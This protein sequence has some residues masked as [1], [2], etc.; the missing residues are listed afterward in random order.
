M[1]LAACAA[2]ACLCGCVATQRDILDLSAQTD[3]LTVQMQA[4]RKSLNTMQ[5]NQADLAVKLDQMRTDVGVL[6]E[7][8]KDNQQ[9]NSRLAAKMDDLASVLTTKVASLGE[10]LSNTQKKL[11]EQRE[12]DRR[13]AQEERDRKAAP[14]EPEEEELKTEEPSAG[15]TPSQIYQSALVQFNQKKYDL[16]A[17]GFSLYL[18]K[19][20]KGEVADLA[21]YHLAGALYAR[22]EYE[23]A[24]RQYAVVLDRF[25]KSDLT[26]ATRLKYAQCLLELKLHPDEAQRYLQSI[27]EDFP[28]SPEAKVAAQMLRKLEVPK[29]ASLPDRRVTY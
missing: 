12:E 29:A 3:S 11:V 2:A 8:L 24:A 26:P 20:P 4:L 21:A 19:Y 15:P 16:A 5:S 10:T 17:Q 27:P 9:S 22:K 14:Q 28:N 23:E 1:R 6:N 7:T 18:Q 25:P 13:L